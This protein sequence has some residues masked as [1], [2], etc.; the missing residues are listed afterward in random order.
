ADINAGMADLATAAGG[1]EHKI[2]GLQCAALDAGRT[3]IAQLGRGARQL[4]TGGIAVHETD[5]TAA[6]ETTGRRVSAPTVRSA[7]Q[8]DGAEQDIAGDRSRGARGIND[9]GVR[10]LRGAGTKQA[11]HYEQ[12]NASQDRHGGRPLSEST[13]TVQRTFR[14]CKPYAHGVLNAAPSA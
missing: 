8:T 3:Q 4:D 5:Q 13:N 7:D 1:K 11:D 6:I 14:W 9:V 2:A 10:R 12:G